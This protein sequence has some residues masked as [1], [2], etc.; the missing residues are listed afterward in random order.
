MGDGAG[1]LAMIE[2]RELEVM[3][4]KRRVLHGIN[5]TLKRGES[6]SIVGESGGGKTTLGLSIIGL[7]EG[8]VR[9]EI[10][11]DGKNLVALAEKEWKAIR[12]NRIAMVFQNVENALNPLYTVLDQVSEPIVVHKLGDSNLCLLHRDRCHVF[13]CNQLA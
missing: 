8:T 13:C 1:R 3:Y 11:F 5:L 4:G 2:L 6:L 9:G 7:V 10:L 12:W